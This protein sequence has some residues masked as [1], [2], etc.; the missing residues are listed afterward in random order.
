ALNLP[1]SRSARLRGVLLPAALLL[2]W[3]LTPGTATAQSG[4]ATPAQ[5]NLPVESITLENGM[6]FLVLERRG[7]PTVAFVGV[8]NVGGVNE[9]LGSTGTSHVLE[10]MLFK[11]TTTV[12]TRNADAELELFARMDSLHGLLLEERARHRPDTTRMAEL[13][14]AIDLLEDEASIYVIPNEFDRILTRAGARGLNATTA[15]EATTY[16]VELP[17]NHAEVWFALESDRMMN[18]VFREFYAER[19]VVMEERRLRVETS[20]AGLL[21][22]AHLA[23]AFTMHPY[24]VPVVGYMSDLETLERDQV[25]AYYRDYYGPGNTVIAVVGDISAREVRRWA[26]RYFGEIPPG[27]RPPPV[28]AQEP[29]QRGTRRVE[30]VADAEPALRMGWRVPAVTHPDAAALAMLS[31]LLTGGRTARLYEALVEETRVATYVTAGMGPGELYP[32]LFT[33][34]LAPRSPHTVE[35]AEAV[36]LQV[37]EDFASELPPEDDLDRVRNQIAASSV[38]SLQSNLG[39]ALQLAGSQAALGDWRETFRLTQAIGEVTGQEVQDVVR[40]YFTQENLT[41]AVLRTSRP[42]TRP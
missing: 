32:R 17:S 38:R 28:L 21:Y 25:A 29:E 11:G 16:F 34:E 27:K 19:D 7:A 12:G 36:V 22:E 8:V 33:V 42:E 6:R 10:H 31:T 4:V 40:K 15:S 18:P 37:L 5:A 39:L 1:R 41:V 2:P 13:R 9:V 3:S 23:A 20:P 26:E 14:E 30:V 35:E 24:G